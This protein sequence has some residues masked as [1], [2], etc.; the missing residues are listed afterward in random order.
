MAIDLRLARQA[1]AGQLGFDPR[2][3]RLGPAPPGLHWFVTGQPGD[4]AFALRLGA[5]GGPGE[6]EVTTTQA[7]ILQREHLTALGLQLVAARLQEPPSVV[8]LSVARRAERRQRGERTGVPRPNR[9]PRLDRRARV[10]RVPRRAR[11]PRPPRAKRPRRPPRPPRTPRPPRKPRP[12]RENTRLGLW[13]LDCGTQGVPPGVKQPTWAALTPDLNTY[14]AP[15]KGCEWKQCGTFE[16]RAEECRGPLAPVLTGVAR[17]LFGERAAPPP[18]PATVIRRRRAEER[19]IRALPALPGRPPITG[20]PPPGGFTTG[21]CLWDLEGSGFLSPAI[22]HPVQAACAPDLNTYF[23]A[24]PGYRWV[25]V[26]QLQG[27]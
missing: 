11:P 19:R 26:R 27:S 16:Q 5:L 22:K 8:P 1:I 17:A 10:N 21:L 12:P 3:V 24:P 6:R 7:G 2:A 13:C 15:P 18:P 14:F 23:G 4:E 20:P 9:A 25:Q